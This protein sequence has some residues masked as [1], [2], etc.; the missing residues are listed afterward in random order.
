MTSG[1]GV[2]STDAAEAGDS[3][4]LGIAVLAT[5][6]L[7]AG[8]FVVS[9]L[10]PEVIVSFG[11]TAA[12]AG[13]ALSG[14]WAVQALTQF[15]G[16]RLVDAWT[17]KT[18]LVGGLATSMAGLGLVLVA[19]AFPLFVLGLAVFGLGV[20]LYTPAIVTVLSQS[21]PGRR[22]RAFS[23]HEVAINVG[24]IA[25]GGLAVIALTA[26]SW[27]FA[28]LPVLGLLIAITGV[29]HR[30]YRAPYRVG[31]ATL[32]LAGTR[33]RLLGDRRSLAMLL[34][35]A[36][37]AFSWQGVAN[38]LPTLLQVEKGFTSTLASQAFAGL[39]VAGIVATLVVAPHGDRFGPVRLAAVALLV[40]ATGLGLLVSTASVVG[41]IAGILLFGFG[42]TAFWPLMLA[43]LVGLL[44]DDTVGGDYGA[45]ST[46]FTTVGSLGS[47]YVGVVADA[48]SFGTAFAGLGGCVFAAA[49]VLAWLARDQSS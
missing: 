38:F 36:L 4:L 20:G 16:G 8:R 11:I 40:G 22:S 32:D 33:S 18:V 35:F 29:T 17:A 7:V 31:P 19:T 44:P 48:T 5:T 25:A 47:T 14:M 28:F 39:F 41:T 45:F 1:A 43:A 26:G 15:P 6:T 10:L 42:G 2:A 34:A 21:F 37:L 23:L 30:R 46:V 24:G 3:A 13:L 9:P 27:R 12:A 49:L